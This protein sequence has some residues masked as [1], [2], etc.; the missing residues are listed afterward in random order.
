[1]TLRELRKARGLSLE[2]VAYLASV[3]AATVS[4]VER[5]L[6][7]PQARTAIR[8]ARALGISAG[9]MRTMLAEAGAAQAGDE[10]KAATG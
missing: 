1:V 10:A 4:R 9:R 5:G 3:D 7:R 8:M 6:V 2:E